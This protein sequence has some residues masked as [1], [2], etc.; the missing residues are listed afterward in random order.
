MKLQEL[1]VYDYNPD[2]C[3]FRSLPS[4]NVV[5]FL[6]EPPASFPGYKVRQATCPKFG[7]TCIFFSYTK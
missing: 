2:S 4:L 6:Q 1:F 5:E 3:L 7:P